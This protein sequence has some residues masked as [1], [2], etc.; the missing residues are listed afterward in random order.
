[1]SAQRI[2][3]PERLTSITGLDVGRRLLAQEA[4][5]RT[6]EAVWDELTEVGRKQEIGRLVEKLRRDL[7]GAWPL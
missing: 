2:T 6:L 4:A 1:M 3:L 5:R 7:E